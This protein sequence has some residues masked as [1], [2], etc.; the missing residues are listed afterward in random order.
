MSRSRSLQISV[1]LLLV[2]FTTR[3]A[4]AD[5]F[6]VFIDETIHIEYGE[7]MLETNSPVYADI[8]RLF[9]IWWLIPFQ[10]A[11]NAPIWVARAAVVLLTLPGFAALLA[12]GRV[13]FR[14]RGMVLVGLLIILST[15]LLFFGRLALADPPAASLI[16]I[17]LYTAYRLR[18]RARP[19]DAILTGGLLFVA[20][21]FK[22][23]SLYYVVIPAAA[24]LALKPRG[25]PWR[26]QILWLA[27]AA[28]MHWPLTSATP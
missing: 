17:A 1:L 8:G 22:A 18:T 6:P 14:T 4:A 24:A 26:A 27:Y 12:L 13:A 3:I 10:P 15:S 5:L 20:Y 19:L 11:A 2:F 16:A 28:T 9:T 25:R 23:A 7:K 21:G